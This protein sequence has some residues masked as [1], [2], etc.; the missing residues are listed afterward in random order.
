MSVAI[1]LGEVPTR[2]MEEGWT[3]RQSAYEL[4]PPYT[5]KLADGVIDVVTHV[6][7]SCSV[8][9]RFDIDECAVFACTPEGDVLAY[10]DLAMAR[11]ACAVAA[12]AQL[13]YS[14]EG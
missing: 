13:G 9:T 4:D 14:P 11:P 3:L 6:L 12:L 8:V 1:Y 10:V 2:P 5:R 7:A